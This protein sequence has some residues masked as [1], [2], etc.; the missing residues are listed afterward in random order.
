MLSG[1][2]VEKARD[3]L[4]RVL[5]VAV[6]GHDRSAAGLTQSC[7]DSW[8][9]SEV[10]REPH[11]GHGVRERP[12]Q[13][14]R[15]RPGAIGAP[16]VYEHEFG[17]AGKVTHDRLEAVEQR[18]EVVL[19]A[20]A[21]DHDAYIDGGCD[22]ANLSLDTGGGKPGRYTAEPLLPIPFNRPYTVGT[23]F[24]FI[25]QAI[26]NGHLSGNG[27]FSRW[28]ERWLETHTGAA[29]AL[30]S[31][32]CTAALEM[33]AIVADVGPGDEVIM[34]SYTFVS[35]ATAFV[36]RGATPVWV[37]VREDTL[38]LNERLV[39]Q[40]ITE[41][42][43]AIVPVHYA[44][45]GCEMEALSEI[46]SRHSLLLIEDAAQGVMSAWGG[47]ARALGAI[48]QLGAVS[49]HET[50]NVTCGEGGALLVNDPRWIE[51]ADVVQ[52]KGTNRRQFNRGAVDKYTW[53]D[54]GSSFLM[55]EVSAAFLWAQLQH[56]QP[57]TDR[58]LQI[59]DAY[60]EAFA[61]L[62]ES[63]I[64]RRP[65]VP[66]SCAHNAHMFYLLTSGLQARDELIAG[67]AEHGI[68]AVFHYVPLHSSPAGRVW[69][70]P[71]GDLSVTD[72]VSERLVRLPLWPGL[73][74]NDVKRVVDSVYA[75]IAPDLA[76]RAV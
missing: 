20:I 65:I 40:A 43:R 21:G 73:A 12:R 4:R 29:R 16:V 5:H 6:H 71:G 17:R 56:A 45:V 67:L 31:P 28:C 62:E 37:D 76:T 58:R 30:L 39:E 50:K 51:R 34:P 72:D 38:N 26:D 75:T 35:T 70:R 60:Y 59:W 53:V 18:H 47:D 69:G 74:E 68:H 49:F 52:Q 64:V 9:L 36:L 33:A 7:E 24:A 8:M 44:G 22:A 54:V 41:R 48:G 19:V 46:A 11:D 61:S 27:Q 13:L 63:G 57:I 25:E 42:T 32:S 14:E 3:V 55:S 66:R 2:C 23:E 15:P 10:S 1:Q